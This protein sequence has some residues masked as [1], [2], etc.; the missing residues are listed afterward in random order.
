M[1]TGDLGMTSMVAAERNLTRE[2]KSGILLLMLKGFASF[3]EVVNPHQGTHDIY[4]CEQKKQQKKHK[5][6]IK[7]TWL[8]NKPDLCQKG[9]LSCLYCYFMIG[10][11]CNS[12]NSQNAMD[13]F[14][15][16][17]AAADQRAGIIIYSFYMSY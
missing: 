17:I 11:C 5:W 14:V 3:V 6:K 12:I 13:N 2:K 9:R 4:R 10:A 1:E 8:I 16:W 15:N 7:S